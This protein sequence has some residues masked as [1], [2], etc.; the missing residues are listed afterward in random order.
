MTAIVTIFAWP[1]C[2]IDD[3]KDNVWKIC[4]LEATL[5]QIT[6]DKHW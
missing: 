3:E 5:G 4:P 6:V 2:V 1:A